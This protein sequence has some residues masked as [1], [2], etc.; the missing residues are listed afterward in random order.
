MFVANSVDSILIA[1]LVFSYSIKNKQ[2]STARFEFAEGMYDV[3]GMRPSWN[4]RA[5]TLPHPQLLQ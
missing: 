3:A 2:Q 5:R 1:I 4:G